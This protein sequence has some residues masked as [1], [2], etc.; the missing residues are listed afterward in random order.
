MSLSRKLNIRNEDSGSIAIEDTPDKG[1]DR[2]VGVRLVKQGDF[3]K[4]LNKK[5]KQGSQKTEH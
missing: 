1:K 5:H 2:L 3:K 4:K